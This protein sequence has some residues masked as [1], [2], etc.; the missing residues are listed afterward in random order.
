MGARWALSIFVA[1]AL[2]TA[3]CGG[4]H[5]QSTVIFDDFSNISVSG[6]GPPSPSHPY[7]PN[8]L[9]LAYG[10]EINLGNLTSRP[11]IHYPVVN[12]VPGRTWELGNNSTRLTGENVA[13]GHRWKRDIYT[14]R[15][16]SITPG[17]RPA[18]WGALD[19]W[20]AYNLA[21]SGS[22]V[23]KTTGGVTVQADV[24][25]NTGYQ[26]PGD[27]VPAA[28]RATAGGIDG[29]GNILSSTRFGIGFGYYSALPSSTQ[30]SWTNFTGVL[31]QNRGITDGGGI[32]TAGLTFKLIVDGSELR[33]L[34][35]TSSSANDANDWRNLRLDINLT[36]G[37]LTGVN[38][39]GSALTLD[40]GAVSNDKFTL[41]RTNYFGMYTAVAQGSD[42]N[43]GN[44]PKF[45]NI[46]YSV[47]EPSS[48]LLA[49]GGMGA[50]VAFVK[51]RRPS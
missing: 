25:V 42:V 34:A 18:A 11:P 20:G 30:P 23:R 13:A 3:I 1:S 36:T 39:A 49:L 6:D 43:F 12:P 7:W 17:D 10:P 24:L 9:Q 27:N 29:S 21:S 41:A 51:Y 48:V 50:L 14:V 38:W 35:T 47:P 46:T 15:T 40:F 16:V 22:Y 32:E 31:V 2:L 8:T 19:A 45:D 37:A 33:T 28:S 44:F 5:A 26:A 4:T